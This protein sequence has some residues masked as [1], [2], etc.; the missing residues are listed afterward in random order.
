M[1]EKD[2]KSNRPIL[3][4]ETNRLGV[5]ISRNERS[6]N[7]KQTLNPEETSSLS[8]KLAQLQKKNEL[9]LVENEK[10]KDELDMKKVEIEVLIKEKSA[11]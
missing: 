1:T 4:S 8:S 2:Q 3:G 9:L 7:S 5:E 10:L 11:M 6:I